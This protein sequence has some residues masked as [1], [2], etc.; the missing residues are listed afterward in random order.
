MSAISAKRWA[1]T[2]KR[3]FGFLET[4]FGMAVVGT[5]DHSNWETT[6]TYGGNAS[7]V[8]VRYSV[9]FDRTEVELVRLVGGKIPAVPI[10]I[11]ADT[12]I[13]RGWLDNLLAVREPVAAEE[14][15]HLTGLGHG[16]VERA[17][18]FEA[19]AL[20]KYAADILSGDLR[21][22][23]DIE[24]H[25]RQ[26]V[27]QHP[28]TITL[29]L[30]EGTEQQEVDRAVAKAKMLDPRVAINVRFYRKPR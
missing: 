3:H 17:L 30:P 9:E 15:R 5:D 19:D 7:A 27:S 12:P 26:Q 23:A 29:N 20:R 1:R 18:R 13:N 8:I 11:H 2:V 16:S 10:F 25:I 4:D 21:G 6:V 24:R 22:F 14:L 28:P